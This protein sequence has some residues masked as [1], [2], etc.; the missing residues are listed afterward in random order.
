MRVKGTSPGRRRAAPLSRVSIQIF[1][2]APERTEKRAVSGA[3][4]RYFRRR[5][6]RSA[7]RRA[8]TTPT[9]RFART[10]AGA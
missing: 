8:L 3:G 4:E 5:V 1:A 2:V 9:R 10:G 6:F 7:A